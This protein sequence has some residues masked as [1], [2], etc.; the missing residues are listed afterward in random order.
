MYCIQTSVHDWRDVKFYSGEEKNWPKLKA[1]ER[2]RRKMTLRWKWYI[3]CSQTE[4]ESKDNEKS[5]MKIT[6]ISKENLIWNTTIV[7]V[8]L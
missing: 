2:E 3:L 4:L 1:N 7:G 6:L 5:I 8:N